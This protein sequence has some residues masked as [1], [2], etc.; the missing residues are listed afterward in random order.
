MLQQNHA[1]KVI[2]LCLLLFFSS[3]ATAQTTD[4]EA[5]AIAEKVMQNMGG[6]KNWEK[7]RYLAWT[8]NDQY[9]IWDK[10]ENRFRWEQGDQVVV[11]DT[12]RKEGKV[13]VAGEEMQDQEEK[14]KLLDRAYA[15]WINNSYW[16]VMPF[17]L[18]DPG[19][20]LKY[21][22]EAQTM[23]GAPADVLEMTFEEVG[24]TP[25]N[26]YWIWVD[27]DKGLVTQ[28]AFFRNYQDKEPTFTRRW[29]NYQDYGRI[30]LANDRSNPQSDF[31]LIHVAAPRSVPDAVFNSPVPVE[32][33]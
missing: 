29:A 22:N 16:L 24:L 10:H 27:K 9:Q 17:K 6:K 5:Q 3:S 4:P 8:F 13:Y 14:R 31:E 7:T 19:V 11:L 30:K 25:Q 23:D 21:L 15:L 32:K 33:F 26:K 1:A 18:Q 20:N 2:L 28:W 12:E